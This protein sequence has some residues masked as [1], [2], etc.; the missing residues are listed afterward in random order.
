MHLVGLAFDFVCPRCFWALGGQ[1]TPQGS[2]GRIV[3]SGALDDRGYGCG[4]A[5]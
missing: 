4:A 1:A 2:T 5:A 3:V